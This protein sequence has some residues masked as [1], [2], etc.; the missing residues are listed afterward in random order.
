[1][2][3]IKRLFEDVVADYEEDKYSIVEI[4]Q[5]N[6]VSIGFV[7]YAIELDRAEREQ[8]ESR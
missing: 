1:M 8:E 5:R 6:G 4:A 3:R 2:S 7:I